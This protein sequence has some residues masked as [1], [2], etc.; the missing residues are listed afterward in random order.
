MKLEELLKSVFAN[1]K[2]TTFLKKA[3][4]VLA[5]LPISVAACKIG[6]NEVNLIKNKLR[7][8][9]HNDTLNSLLMMHVSG[10]LPDLFSTTKCS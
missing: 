3:M 4:S 10:P 5:E 7:S 1:E 9:L 6:F 8:L 2:I